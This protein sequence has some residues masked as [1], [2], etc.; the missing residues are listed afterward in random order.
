MALVSAKTILQTFGHNAF[1]PKIESELFALVLAETNE[2]SIGRP[3]YKIYSL[4]LFGFLY[5]LYLKC[6]LFICYNGAKCCKLNS[7]PSGHVDV[8]DSKVMSD[9]S[10]ENDD[11]TPSVT[12]I[13]KRKR[14]QYTPEQAQRALKAVENGMSLKKLHQHTAYQEAL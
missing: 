6:L 2:I 13:I 8:M 11:D 10:V 3:L 5:I 14:K 7:S 1:L 4:S 9:S 12:P